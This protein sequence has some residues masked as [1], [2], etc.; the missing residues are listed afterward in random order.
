MAMVLMV[1]RL[2]LA[3]QYG[4]VLLYVR[5]YRITSR[6]LVLTVA[7]LLVT[8]MIFLGTYFCFRGPK[9]GES[10]DT[11]HPNHAYVAW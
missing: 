6:P 2:T 4:T 10:I 5:R 7:V 11:L 8:A 9:A 3:I 1:S